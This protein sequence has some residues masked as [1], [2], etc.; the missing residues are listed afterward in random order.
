MS[1]LKQLKITK[2]EFLRAITDGIKESIHEFMESGDGYSGLIIREYV[3]DEISNKLGNSFDTFL[4]NL[5]IEI[6]LKDMTNKIEHLTEMLDAVSTEIYKYR[7]DLAMKD[8]NDTRI[9]IN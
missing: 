4:N 8:P 5:D 2:E 1:D 9:W 6:P 3:I 7:K